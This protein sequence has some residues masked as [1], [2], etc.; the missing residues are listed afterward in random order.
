MGEQGGSHTIR[1]AR[2]TGQERNICFDFL[3]FS[4][5]RPVT[6]ATCNCR[7]VGYNSLH[8]KE[9]ILVKIHADLN[10]LTIDGSR[11]QL[12]GEFPEVVT[13]GMRV[14]L[15]SPGDFEVEAVLE[16]TTIENGAE[17]WYGILNRDTY[18]DT[19]DQCDD[20]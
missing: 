8:P 14:L 6:I 2:F 15:Y 11:V 10:A 4:S 9:P 13:P 19:P 17:I 3:S 7:V 12:Q 1:V 18:R 20:N 16:K 5:D